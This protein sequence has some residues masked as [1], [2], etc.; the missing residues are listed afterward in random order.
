MH[1]RRSFLQ[2]SLLA[3]S[4]GFSLE[5]PRSPPFLRPAAFWWALAQAAASICWHAC[6]PKASPHSWAS[7]Y[8]VVD[9]KPGANGQIAAQTLLNAP[10][11]GSTYLIAPLIT[12][13]LSQIVY[14]SPATILHATFP[15]GSARAFPVRPGRPRQAPGAQYSGICGL[16]QG[17]PRQP[18]SAAPPW[19]ACRIS[20]DCCWAKRPASTSCMCPTRAARP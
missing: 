7:H 9:N 20:S 5:P 15:G 17:Q 11:D 2:Q 12:P 19:A 10:S 16:A 8:V 4:A 18:T 1:S 6:W 14:K 13:V 3:S